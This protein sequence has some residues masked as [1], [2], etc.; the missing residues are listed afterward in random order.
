M[1]NSFKSHLKIY[2]GLFALFIFLVISV[3]YFLIKST[4]EFSFEFYFLMMIPLWIAVLSVYNYETLRIKKYV[5]EYV[6]EYYPEKLKEFDE[7]PVE[8]LNSDT[9]D[10]LD[11]FKDKYFVSD[12]LMTK[13]NKEADQIT[14]FMYTYFLAMPLLLVT[15]Y[16][17]ILK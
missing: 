12:P 14:L 8:L 9:E 16:F 4:K 1:Q 15:T 2:W 7:K 3:S 10:I 17:V 11:L 5:R 13:L 6:A